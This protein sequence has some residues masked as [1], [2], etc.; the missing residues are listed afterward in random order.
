MRETALLGMLGIATLGFHIDSSF[1]WLRFDQAVALLAVTAV[2]N[3]AVDALSRRLR[4]AQ[5][6]TTP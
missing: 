1:A 2:L 5:R 3:V 6:L 4:S